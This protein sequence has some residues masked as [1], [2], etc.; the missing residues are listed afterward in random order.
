MDIEV[1]EKRDSEAKSRYYKVLCD[2]TS[3]SLMSRHGTN[4]VIPYIALIIGFAKESN[5]KHNLSTF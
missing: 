5:H 1:S 4:I 2:A 3:S